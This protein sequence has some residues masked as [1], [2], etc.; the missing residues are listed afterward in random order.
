M[1]NRLNALLKTISVRLTL[2]YTLVFGLLAGALIVY[3]SYNSGRLIIAQV[4]VAAEEEIKDLS[5]IYRSGGAR[6]LIR[7]IERRSRNP[8]ANLYLI[9]DSAGRIITGNVRQL[10][11]GILSTTGWHEVPFEYKPLVPDG[12]SQNRAIAQVFD[13]PDGLRLLVG[14]D[15][16]DVS[17]F[18]RVIARAAILALVS[19]LLIGIVLWMLIGRRALQRID[20]LGEASARIVAGDLSQRLPVS[21]VGDE[22][23][24]LS[25]HLNGMIGRLERLNSGVVEVSDSIAHDLK[26]PLTRLRNQAEAA[27]GL[28]EKER[29]DALDVVVNQADGL[30]RTF[31]ALLMISQVASGAR[32]VRFSEVDIGL[33]L[34][35]LGELFAPSVEDAGGSLEVEKIG[36]VPLEISGNRELLAQ[37]ITNLIDNALKYASASGKPEIALLAKSGNDE[38]VLSVADNGPGIPA[39]QR[40]AAKQRF[41]R[42]ERDRS[43]PGSGLGLSLVDAIVKLHGGILELEDN[44]PGL[45]AK[46]RLP[47]Q[48]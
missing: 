35:D 3:V 20:Q 6:L 32:T 42:L 10:E 25:L 40:D 23:D 7:S 16:S 45:V 29:K 21:G 2:V 5:L 31:D 26:T 13:L 44:R 30:I 41:V 38:V 4:R 46:L 43:G 24:R 39:D 18:R 37:A 11:Q 14:R 48:S 1:I 36:E 27:L 28:P 12:G 9:G 8:G 34:D 33:L 15:I 22:F 47:L 17:E 19:L